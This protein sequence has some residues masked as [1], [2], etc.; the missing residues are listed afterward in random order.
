MG[1]SAK[2]T[3]VAEVGQEFD[4]STG[5]TLGR[6]DEV[7]ALRVVIPSRPGGFGLAR[8]IFCRLPLYAPW[9]GCCRQLREVVELPAFQGACRALHPNMRYAP[10]TDQERAWVALRRLQKAA[11][12]FTRRMSAHAAS[13]RPPL[14]SSSSDADGASEMVRSVFT[15]RCVNIVPGSADE[16]AHW[17]DILLANVIPNLGPPAW[18]PTP[19]LREALAV[20]LTT[21]LPPRTMHRQADVKTLY[22][23][24]VL[25]LLARVRRASDGKV[26]TD[27]DMALFVAAFRINF[28]EFSTLAE[29]T[30]RVRGLRRQAMKRFGKKGP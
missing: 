16:H 18:E 14:P 30:E 22:R 25:V 6:P 4:H 23:Q 1:R 27:R 28:G 21:D 13:D 7:T 3:T 29:L 17:Q 11:L 5:L 24:T 9:P 15:Q 20:I 10:A 26:L 2:P 12:A 19:A 8:E